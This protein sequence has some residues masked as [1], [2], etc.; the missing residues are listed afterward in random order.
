MDSHL[1]E[2]K[3][4]HDQFWRTAKYVSLVALALVFVV[5]FSVMGGQVL[6]PD[7]E[8]GRLEF[9]ISLTAVALMLTG[10]YFTAFRFFKDDFFFFIAL[11]WLANAL[12]LIP[13]VNGPGWSDQGYLF[14]RLVT[15]GLSLCSTLAMFIA[16]L[17]RRRRTLPNTK[18]IWGGVILAVGLGLTFLFISEPPGLESMSIEQRQQLS[19]LAWL[20]LPG[21][22]LSFVSLWFAGDIAELHLDGNNHGW[23]QGLIYSFRA[24]AAVQFLYPFFPFLEVKKVILIPFLIAQFAKVGNAVCLLA[25]IQLTS[26]RRDVQ[27]LSHI[28]AQQAQLQTQERLVRLGM[29]ASSIK[30][31]VV[32]P[33]A[34]MGTELE[35]L[36]DRYQHDPRITRKLQS[37]QDLMDR[38]YAK[39][40]VVDIFRGDKEFFNRDLYMTKINMLELVHRAV[41]LIK[42]EMAVLKRVDSRD[43]I[44]VEG[45][46][47]WVRAY[48]PMFEQVIVNVIKNGLE[49]ID[50]AKRDRGL[51]TI[52]VSTIDVENSK[53]SRW[54][55]VE[56]HD[57]GEGIP[58]QNIRKLATLFTT[59]AKKK[60]NSGIGLFISS[61]I[62]EIHDGEIKFESTLGVG[63]IVTILMPEF[64]ALQKAEGKIHTSSEPAV[65][66]PV[67]STPNT[68]SSS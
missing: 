59:R 13:D 9:S 46:D 41:K 8:A 67:T 22:V 47:V 61:K 58:P 3:N 51:V 43:F 2:S 56:V 42:N 19:P 37:L 52:K 35:T 34:A 65:I 28:S 44:K 29:L 20:L 38:I 32:T 63:T 6:R 27:R 48:G 64:N 23:D 33:L 4:E 66:E 25:I 55:K 1:A 49:A 21:S 5:F 7:R 54:V 39:V 16:L 11:G 31:D 60:P 50:E 68:V 24:Y 15:H 14:Y 45:R 26:A 17:T 36:K 12:Y 53:Y 30:H 57:N 10:L 40:Q 62:L 18:L